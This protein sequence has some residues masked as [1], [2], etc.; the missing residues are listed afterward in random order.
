MLIERLKR[1][2]P[3]EMTTTPPPKSPKKKAFEGVVMYYGYRFYDPE[4]GRW[5][6]RDPIEEAGGANLY[7]FVGNDGVGGIDLLGLRLKSV[8]E[9][10]C[11]QIFL[12]TG[13]V[14]NHYSDEEPAYIPRE[15]ERRK[16]LYFEQWIPLHERLASWHYDEFAFQAIIYNHTLLNGGASLE[17]Y[18][19]RDNKGRMA[20]S[21]AFDFASGQLIGMGAGAVIGRGIRAIRLC[22]CR[23]KITTIT[24][25]YGPAGPGQ[26][27]TYPE[28]AQLTKPIILQ[29]GTKLN[30]VFDSR[31]MLGAP[32]SQ[33]FGSS[34]SPSWKTPHYA[35]VAIENR[36]LNWPGVVNNA[37]LGGRFVITRRVPAMSRPS[38]GG[39]EPEILISRWKNMS[40]DEFIKQVGSD[41]PIAPW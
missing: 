14:Y 6:S 12:K 37:Q 13:L 31:Y 24:P 36:G 10:L 11:H 28:T 27:V 39:T 32:Y 3:N 5:P 41:I 16:A 30:R 21:F 7:G 15:N 26:F 19:R 23:G 20:T 8:N 18:L 40:C 22:C 29:S 38:L 1:L 25:V 35:S 34:Y 4:T 17:T 9:L 2:F 33:P